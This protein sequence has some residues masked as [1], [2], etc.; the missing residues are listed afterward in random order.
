VLE[1]ADA[2]DPAVRM[3][4]QSR[5]GAV[6][7]GDAEALHGGPPV[8]A[9]LVQNTNPMSVAPDQTRVKQGFARD[10]LFVAVHEQFMTE[11]A[12]MADIVLPATMFMEH[13]DVYT[14]GGNQYI[15]L[16]P[17]LIDPPGEC[18]SNHDLICA[19]GARLGAKHPGFDMDPR[20]HI[21]R[22]L[23]DSGWGT[24]ADIAAGKFV[25]AQP[26]F[27]EA[28]F[29]AGFHWPDK[30]FRFKPDWQNVPF[31]NAGPMGPWRE[32]PA[33]P[34]HWAVIEEADAAHPFRLATSPSRSFLN[35]TFN[36][37]PTSLAREGRP[38]VQV[39]SKDA[40][41]LGIA[42]GDA[43]ALGNARGEVRLHAKLFDG[44]RR[45]VLIS[46]GVWPNRAFADGKGI[47]TLTGADAAAP[48]GG[49]AFHDNRV[50]LRKA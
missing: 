26:S 8:K 48:F 7:C 15:T 12:A 29:T 14:G 28:H 22:I 21:D 41:A 43:V 49:S 40:A 10:D 23:R 47:N 16:G 13:D 50:W 17:K 37:T 42:D 36:E 2:R 38:N 1:G 25:D 46:E 34:D 44:L 11:T 9:M 6:L 5:I 45:G 32:M 33:L 39:H 19:L 20:Q 27:E 4:D 18:R 35:S 3:L 31:K 30:K 24:Y